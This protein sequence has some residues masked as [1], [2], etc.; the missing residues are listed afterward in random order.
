M[1]ISELHS[2]IGRPAFVIGDR[3]RTVFSC[4]L[5]GWV[6]AVKLHTDKKAYSYSLMHEDGDPFLFP[7]GEDE[8]ELLELDESDK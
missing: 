3:V 8:L 4:R 5:V 7:Y 1:K 2:L 6:C